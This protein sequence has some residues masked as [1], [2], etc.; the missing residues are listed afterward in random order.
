M[1]KAKGMEL[2]DICGT[3][4]QFLVTFSTFC[5]DLVYL[6]KDAPRPTKVDVKMDYP[7]ACDGL[8]VFEDVHLVHSVEQDR[9][10]SS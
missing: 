8:T 7:K 3:S 4:Q 9:G 5:A 6:S 2:M 10:S 1:T